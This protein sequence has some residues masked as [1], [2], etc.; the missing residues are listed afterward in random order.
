ML[1]SNPADPIANA[2]LEDR[3]L[4]ATP[5]LEA[6]GNAR[7][8]RNRNSS[9]F[10]KL[11]KIFFE[12][13]TGKLRGAAIES[14]LLEKPRVT[15]LSEND[16]NYHVF[17]YLLAGAGADVRARLQ[18]QQ[19]S[20]TDFR[21]LLAA[22]QSSA[23][24]GFD[25]DAGMFRELLEAF[26]VCGVSD[27]ERG[28]IFD[29]LGAILHLGNCEFV[30][31]K[32]AKRLAPAQRPVLGTVARLLQIEPTTLEKALT[33]RLLGSKSRASTYSVPL[34]TAGVAEARESVA[35]V[36]Y[37]SLF[38]WLVDRINRMLSAN[39]AVDD[40]FVAILDIF[41]FENFAHNSFEQLLI[42]YANEKLHDS[43]LESVFREEQRT[44]EAEGLQ[45]QSVSFE[46][47]SACLTLL[48]ARPSGILALLDEECLLPTGSDDGY[49][50]KAELAHAQS[51][52]FATPRAVNRNARAE[53]GFVVKHFADDVTYAVADFVEK[54][55]D[56]L[57]ADLI[58]ALQS[59]KNPFIC[60]MLSDDM[61]EGDASRSARA[62]TVR[63]MTSAGSGA[64]NGT[65]AANARKRPTQAT[66]F[67]SQ[68]DELCRMIQSVDRHFIRCVK[69]NAAATPGYI[70]E[71]MLRAQLRYTGVVAAARVR[72]AGYALR[73]PFAEFVERFKTTTAAELAGLDARAAAAAIAQSV[74]ALSS[75][76]SP[77]SGGGDLFQIGRTRVFLKQT[78]VDMLEEARLRLRRQLALELQCAMRAALA[79]ARFEQALAEHRRR[80]EEE[81]RRR[82]EEERR[83][84]EEEERR[85]REE[86]ERRRRE[87]E[88]RRWRE[89][90]ERRRREEEERQRRA[91][92]EEARRRREAEDEQQRRRRDE[93]ERRMRDAN[94]RIGDR[95]PVTSARQ[96]DIYV[97]L[98]QKQ[99]DERASSVMQPRDAYNPVPPRESYVPPAVSAAEKSTYSSAPRSQSLAVRNN[100][101]PRSALEYVQLGPEEFAALEREAQY[102]IIPPEDDE[103][104]AVSPG[105]SRRGLFE[106]PQPNAIPA[107]LQYVVIAPEDDIQ[108][109]PPPQQQQQPRW[110]NAIADVLNDL[111]YVVMPPEEVLTTLPPP[112][113]ELFDL[114]YVVMPPEEDF[115][116]PPSGRSPRQPRGGFELQY[117]VMPP[118]EMAAR[119]GPSDVYVSAPGR[120]S[121]A[122][123]PAPASTSSLRVFDTEEG[124]SFVTLTLAAAMLARDAMAELGRLFSVDDFRRFGLFITQLARRRRSRCASTTTSTSARA[125]R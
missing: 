118:E 68:L 119:A 29:I 58:I 111:Q 81:R 76:L 47:N 86:E 4:A 116:S 8:V 85:R 83:R 95:S 15:H 20:A 125:W 7:T 122:P 14:Y 60:A 12:R 27:E 56:R 70:D 9:R 16:T 113:A 5:I 18:L 108:V 93:D 75:S 1:L 34:D 94:A 25:N 41:G 90:E 71:P 91:A 45:W 66:M 3:I 104:V 49:L 103:D 121:M 79:R 54:N 62:T 31:V 80:K 36:L 106:T 110:Q 52:H 92:D 82:E 89:E 114:Q 97:G 10:G 51:R 2:S 109:P 63:R 11:I 88:E 39:H 6:F 61:D 87:E 105:N 22:G 32:E 33:T 117:I 19:R 67:R 124:A 64:A 43:F 40:R 115:A 57:H 78:A 107:D 72:A 50:R 21:Y 28:H 37:N 98:P 74:C 13:N 99:P 77:R 23:R 84:R 100:A 123:A 59:S 101:V 53:R 69:P 65:L 38:H 112:D 17:Y 46:D 26:R 96:D 73:L 102:T 55:Q 120:P 48:E 35:R 44:Y 24:E 42:N 30:F